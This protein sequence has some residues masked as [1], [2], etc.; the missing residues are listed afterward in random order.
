M[1]VLLLIALVISGVFAAGGW[2]TAMQT[3]KRA[4]L[5][6][7]EVAAA[8]KRI[9]HLESGV[10]ELLRTRRQATRERFL[11]LIEEHKGA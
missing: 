6:E 9:A 11:G 4:K 10:R 8:N 2:A 3:E 1:E 7:R 5:A